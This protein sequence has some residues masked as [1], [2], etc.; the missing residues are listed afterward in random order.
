MFAGRFSNG[1]RTSPF[2]LAIDPWPLQEEHWRTGI[3]LLMTRTTQINFPLLATLTAVLLMP[4]AAFAQDGEWKTPR[5]PDG[6]PPVDERVL[7]WILWM[8]NSRDRWEGDTLVVETTNFRDEN[9]TNP[10]NCCPGTSADLTLVERFTRVDANSIETAGGRGG[11]RQAD[12]SAASAPRQH[13]R[14]APRGSPTSDGRQH[15]DGVNCLGPAAGVT[16][17]ARPRTRC[18]SAH[19]ARSPKEAACSLTLCDA[20]ASRS[21]RFC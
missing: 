10:F 20:S 19:S 18:G 11:P 6:Q 1:S 13:A 4:G 3:L 12:D 16:L 2:S 7:L 9:Y 5:T 15:P 8:G 21:S 14:S 17:T